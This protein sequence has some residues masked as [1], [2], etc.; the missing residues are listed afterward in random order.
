MNTHQWHYLEQRH[1][2][3]RKQLYIKGKKLLA[4]D[5]WSDMIVNSDSPQAAAKAWDL[6]IEA[7]AEAI[8]YCETHQHLIEQEA[9]LEKKYLESKGYTVEPKIINR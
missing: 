9:L 6:P 7:I 1:D 2:S 5:V 4:S 8:K 3:W